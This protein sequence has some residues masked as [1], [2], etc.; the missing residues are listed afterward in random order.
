[1]QLLSNLSKLCFSLLLF[2]ILPLSNRSECDQN[3][4]MEIYNHFCEIH[5][6]QTSFS[7]LPNPIRIR[8][9]AIKFNEIFM[10]QRILGSI[11][12]DSSVA[13]VKSELNFIMINDRSFFVDENFFKIDFYIKKPN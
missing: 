13:V 11:H 1:M 12:S 9:F 3:A 4:I 10:A 8:G 7:L 2:S 6:Q 5:T